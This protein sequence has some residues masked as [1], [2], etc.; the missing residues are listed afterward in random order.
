MA[1]IANCTKLLTDPSGAYAL[2]PAEAQAAFADLSLYTNAESCPMCASAIQWSG[3]REYVY[4][5]SI[6][7]LIRRGW[8]QI[9][10]AS[11][12]VFR[13]S[14]DMGATPRMLAGVLANETDGY[15]AWQ[16]DPARGCPRGCRRVE[17]V[18]SDERD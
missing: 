12:D 13:Q 6:D 3:F 9:R 15:F 11:A 17:G 2:S 4:G 8:G 5:T 7:T 10:I 14:Y 16:Y 18:C 1:A